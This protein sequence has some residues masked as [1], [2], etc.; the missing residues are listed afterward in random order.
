MSRE[1]QFAL[2]SGARFV[3]LDEAETDAADVRARIGRLE[4]ENIELRRV[5]RK[6]CRDLVPCAGGGGTCELP[7]TQAEKSG[8]LVCD[9]HVRGSGAL[10]LTYGP[11]VT[12]AL[13]LVGKDPP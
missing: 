6:L 7:A 10:P 2:A 3:E 5:L 11:T 4:A 12:L 13:A 1:G 8:R 9:E